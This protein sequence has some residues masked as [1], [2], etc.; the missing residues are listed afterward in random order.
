MH[1]LVSKNAAEY[2]ALLLGLRI[3][4]VLDILRL[5]VLRNSLLIIN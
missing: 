2:E 4:I 1:F 5:R 3:N